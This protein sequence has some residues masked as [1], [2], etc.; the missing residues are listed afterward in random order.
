[1]FEDVLHAI[2]DG[3]GPGRHIGDESIVAGW[4][5]EQA[6]DEERRYYGCQQVDSTNPRGA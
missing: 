5:E 2:F 3:L 6:D 4:S 1:M